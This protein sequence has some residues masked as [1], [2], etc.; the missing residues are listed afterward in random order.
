MTVTSCSAFLKIL[1]LVF[2]VVEGS[3]GQGRRLSTRNGLGLN[4]EDI[5]LLVPYVLLK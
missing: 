2:N 1:A 4:V 3:V 5:D